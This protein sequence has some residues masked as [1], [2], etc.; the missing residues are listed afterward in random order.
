MRA[1]PKRIGESGVE[2]IELAIC[3]KKGDNEM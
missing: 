1:D 2:L 3:M